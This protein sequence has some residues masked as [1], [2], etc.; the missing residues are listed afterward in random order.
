MTTE[1]SS[2]IDTYGAYGKKGTSL[3]VRGE[4]HLACSEHEGLTD[5]HADTVTVVE[6]GS[7]KKEPFKAMQFMPGFILVMVGLM[8]LAIFHI[9]RERER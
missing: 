7:V 2:P 8:M 5:V 3:Q 4:F 1:A 6:K 9:M